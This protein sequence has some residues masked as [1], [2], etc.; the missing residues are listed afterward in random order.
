MF[1]EMARGV[2]TPLQCKR[3][4]MC[5]TAWRGPP[6]SVPSRSAAEF[7]VSLPFPYL[8]CPTEDRAQ[9]SF[10]FCTLPPTLCLASRVL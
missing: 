4:G 1:A 3:E 7:R 6:G 5:P 10:G 9:A 2:W 8:H